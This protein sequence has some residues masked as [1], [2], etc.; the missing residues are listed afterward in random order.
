M[1]KPRYDRSSCDNN[2]TRFKPRPPV[3]DVAPSWTY[4]PLPGRL[5]MKSFDSP[6]FPF[7]NWNLSL[8][9]SL[10]SLSYHTPLRDPLQWTNSAAVPVEKC[11][12][13]FLPIP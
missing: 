12:R 2:A 3:E 6:I 8:L 1:D 4:A 5:I 7:S 11:R 13:Q 9:H 10:Y